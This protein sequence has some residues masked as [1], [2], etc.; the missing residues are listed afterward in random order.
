MKEALSNQKDR[1]EKLKTNTIAQ[2]RAGIITGVIS[3]ASTYFV[4][5]RI[6]SFKKNNSKPVYQG[7]PALTL[8]VNEDE[9]HMGLSYKINF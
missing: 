9:L 8:D 1:F 5:K 7:F 4:I 2:R 3:I 6:R